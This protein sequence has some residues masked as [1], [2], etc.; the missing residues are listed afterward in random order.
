MGPAAEFQ[1][2]FKLLL[3][4]RHRISTQIYLAFGGAV[5]LTIAASLV[6]WFSFDRVG[7]Q[8]A[9]VNEGSVPEMTAAFGIAQLANELVDAG[10]RLAATTNTTD[11]QAVAA[12]ISAANVALVG[13]LALLQGQHTSEARFNRMRSYLDELTSNNYEIQTGMVESF[14]RD[15]LL[16]QLRADIADVDR[17]LRSILAPAADD[18]WFYMMTGYRDPDEP[19]V[20]AVGRLNE[21]ELSQYRHLA[22]LVADTDYARQTLESGFGVSDP[23]TL[24][25]LRESFESAISRM[26]HNLE[27]IRGLDLGEEIEPL[28]GELS[29]LGLGSQGSLELL[30]RHFRVLER[31]G[32]LLAQNRSIAVELLKEVDGFVG[33]AN[34]SV[35]D[36]A[37]ASDQAV[38]AG[39]IILAALS[40]VSVGGAALIAWLFIGRILLSR[41][42]ILL[43][44]MRQM[45][46]GDLD[47]E[48]DTSGRDE[49]SE[50]ANALEVFRKASL[51]AIELDEV[52]R[53]N[54]QLEQTNEELTETVGQRDSA[55]DDLQR[56]QN[57]IVERDKLAAIGELTA[58]VAH[59]I[60]NPLNFI[61]NFAEGSEEILE[62]LTEVIDEAAEEME[63]TQRD[64]VMEISGELKD[65]LN[66]IQSNTNRA[67]RIVRDMLL[68]SRGA[69]EPQLTDINS[70]VEEN[71][72]LSFHSARATNSDFQL[73]LVT[74]FDPEAGRVE[75]IPQDMGRVIINMVTNAGFATNE[76]RMEIGDES[77]DAESY[78][79]TVYLATKRLDEEVEI[80]VKD[81]GTGIPSEVIDSIFNPFFTTKDPNQGTGLGLALCADI[82]RQHGGSIS[83][84]TEPGE[85]TE[86]TILIPITQPVIEE[87]ES[88]LVG[89]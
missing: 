52:R 38:F 54:D 42:Q 17:Q 79:P 64:L 81:N 29:E 30:D 43:G 57:Q 10:P 32:E 16:E 28:I 37:V 80:R 5:L 72:R 14:L 84:E 66:R 65:S 53:L 62:E 7:I 13:Q 68:M 24:E 55:L 20:A 63:E 26:N 71:A 46:D 3:E 6:G 19:P 83:V 48:V 85:F 78:M 23:S 50:M 11:F 4:S 51:D 34:A 35:E 39:K 89:V 70:L 8:Q 86:M 27:A 15:V 2:L 59:E 25:P 74:D 21:S 82:I 77:F 33:L 75:V 36:A 47:V 45:A 88:D 73:D 9:R 18:Q 31:R 61:K 58:G 44:S 60:R 41:L 40:V 67:E 69:S 76:R 22:A 49:V 56:A 12:D 1:R 87:A